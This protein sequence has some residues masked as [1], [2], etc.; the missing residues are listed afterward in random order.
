VGA[1]TTSV[2]S[3]AQRVLVEDL[4]DGPQARGH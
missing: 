3:C 2:S 1:M 4:G